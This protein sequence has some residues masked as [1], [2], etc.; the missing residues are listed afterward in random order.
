MTVDD[1]AASIDRVHA[2]L[3]AD[4]R[5]LARGC[6]FYAP[7]AA[8]EI[9]AGRVHV[10]ASRGVLTL[11]RETTSAPWTMVLALDGVAWPDDG[12]APTDEPTLVAALAAVTGCPSAALESTASSLRWLGSLGADVGEEP[13]PGG[14]WKRCT[15]MGPEHGTGEDTIAPEWP[16]VDLAEPDGHVVCG[17]LDPAHE[18]VPPTCPAPTPRAP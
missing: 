2:A 16:R 9:V 8:V 4:I 7:K 12:D 6:R 3:P 13:A 17:Y 1:F 15:T 14:A 11:R 5:T 18:D 10:T